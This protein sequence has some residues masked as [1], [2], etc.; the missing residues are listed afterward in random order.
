ME[1]RTYIYFV[2]GEIIVEAGD[3]RIYK[4]DD[5]LFLEKGP[6]HNLWA[7]SMEI[8]DYKGQ[9]GD[10]PRGDCLEIGLGLGVASNYILSCPRIKSLTTV[11]FDLDVINAYRYLEPMPDPKH[12]IVCQSGYIYMSCTKEK[13]DFIFLDFYNIL[14]KETLMVLEQY[15]KLAENLLRPDGVIKAWFDPYTTD[16]EAEEFF[17]LFGDDYRK[18]VK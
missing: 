4:M 15:K 14:D 10:S 13:Y 3:V 12:R 11:E 2:D 17:K 5:N 6:G 9:I 1:K 16:E 18:F 7:D 8:E